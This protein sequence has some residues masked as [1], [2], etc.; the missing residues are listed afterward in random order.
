MT[1]TRSPARR[2]NAIVVALGAFT[3]AAVMVVTA[4]DSSTSTAKITASGSSHQRALAALDAVLARHEV[5]VVARASQGDPVLIARWTDNYGVDFIGDAEVRWKIEPVRTPPRDASGNPL[6]HITNP[7]PD[8]NWTPPTTGPVDASG[9]PYWQ[10]N[11]TN[12]MYRIAGEA[13]I[14]EDP[15]AG[16]GVNASGDPVIRPAVVVQG[17]RYASVLNEPLFRY[18]IFYA[19]TG[20]KGDLE[21]SHADNVNIQ[22]SVHTNG[23]LYL[24]SGLKV[25][26]KV[27]RLGALTGTLAPAATRIGPDA[28]NNLVRVNGVDGI[29]RLSKPLMYTILNG[30]TL[31]NDASPG[32]HGNPETTTGPATITWGAAASYDL[33]TASSALPL[34]LD[35]PGA[36][37]GSI[38]A[39]TSQGRSINPYRIKD[40][41]GAITEST[42]SNND[43][44]RQINNV[45]MRGVSYNN[46]ASGPLIAN[47][48][49]DT[50][51]AADAKWTDL[52][53]TST[54]PGFAG[55]ARSKL[56]GQNI[57]LLPE[58]MR[59]RSFEAQRLQ[60]I[61]TDGDPA[62][63]EHEDARPFFVKANGTSTLD[64]PQN[65]LPG[66]PTFADGNVVEDPGQYLRYALGADGRYMVRKRTGEGWRIRDLN[67]AFP[68][69]PAK[70]GLIIRERPTP[71]ADYWPGT[72]PP[73]V[74]DKIDPRWLPYAYGKHWYPNILPFTVAD[75][76]E[77]CAPSN[78]APWN[79]GGWSNDPLHATRINTTH[80]GRLPSYAAG[81]RLSITTAQNASGVTNN[82]YFGYLTNAAAGS[83]RQKPYFYAQN[84]RFVH[85][86]RQV[87]NTAQNGLR[88][89]V[90]NDAQ[91]G[92]P[93]NVS[94]QCLVGGPLAVNGDLVP[95]TTPATGIIAQPNVANSATGIQTTTSVPTSLAGARRSVRFDGFLTAAANNTYQLTA[96]AGGGSEGV[97]IWVNGELCFMNWGGVVRPNVPVRLLAGRP[98][99]IQID[100]YNNANAGYAAPSLTVNWQ[101]SDVPL[102]PLAQ[103]P[104]TA[105][106]PPLA[107]PVAN[108]G[109]A[110][111]TFTSVVVRLDKPF[112]IPGPAQ[113]KAGL[114]VR[115]GSGGMS[116]LLNGAA[117][118][119]F[120]GFSPDRGVFTERRGVRHLQEQRSYGTYFIGNGT[121]PGVP[122]GNP[123]TLVDAAGQLSYNSRVDATIT[124]T[125]TL[126]ETA[127]V[128]NLPVQNDSGIV[129]GIATD[130]TSAWSAPT[131]YA[132]PMSKAVG[133]GKIWTLLQG[134]STGPRTATRTQT[135]RK[136]WWRNTTSS[137]VQTVTLGGNV[138]AGVFND[139]DAGKNLDIFNAATGTN[140][141]W[142]NPINLDAGI[143]SGATQPTTGDRWYF[144]GGTSAARTQFKRYWATTSAS[145][146]NFGAVIGVVT[147]SRDTT[148]GDATTVW[149][150][151]GTIQINKSGEITNATAGDIATVTGLTVGT[152]NPSLTAAAPVV[153]Y[154][155]IADPPAPDF[156]EAPAVAVANFPG[157]TFQVQR[158]GATVRFDLNSF[159]TTSGNWLAAAAPQY[160][161]T[162]GS[163][164]WDLTWPASIPTT[165][166]LTQGFRPDVYTGAGG[167]G[168]SVGPVP[169][170]PTGASVAQKANGYGM[171]DDNI[172][173]ANTATS[174]WL[175]ISKAGNVLTFAYS[176]DGTNWTA[177]PQ[178]LDIA[179]WGSHLLVG[180]AVQSGDVNQLTT[181]NY[182]DMRITTTEPTPNNIIDAT[183]W[184][185][186]TSSQD[187]M[188][189][190]LASQ[191]Q[192][193][194]GSR[195]IT[196][197]FFT[198]T[199][200]ATGRRNA[201]EDWIYN[202]REFWSQ[203]RWWEHRDDAGNRVSKDDETSGT[204]T[205]FNNTPLREAY[206]KT[207]LL[208]LD[209][210]AVQSYLRQ[211]LLSAAVADL[212]IPGVSQDIQPVTSD[213]LLYTKF[214]GLIYAA[215]TNRYPWN[216]NINRWIM[217]NLL[218]VRDID[219]N[220]TGYSGDTKGVNPWSP[221]WDNQLPNSRPGMDTELTPEIGNRY[222]LSVGAGWLTVPQGHLL[223]PYTVGTV[224]DGKEITNDP[225]LKPQQFHHGVRL[226]NA[227]SIDWEFAGTRAAVNTRSIGT[228]LTKA[229]DWRWSSNPAFGLSKLSIVTP[230]SLYVQGNVNVARHETTRGTAAGA[231]AM[232]FSPLA[233]MGDS[234]VLLSNAWR[235]DKAH[236]QGLT[237][238]NVASSACV[239][240]TGT[241]ATMGTLG[242]KA[243]DTEY[244][245]ALATHNLP[246]TRDRVAEGQSSPFI[247]TMLLME[248]WNNRTMSYLGSLVVMDSRRYT[249][250]F[251]H[252]SYK[253]YG[254]TPF[255]IVDNGATWLA[256]LNGFVYQ[257]SDWAPGGPGMQRVQDNFKTGLYGEPALGVAWTGY[258]P[259]ILSE[260]TRVY[261]FNYDLL[262]EEGTPPFAP[263]GVTTSGVGGWARI[264]K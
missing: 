158:D 191:Y 80:A 122:A 53:P 144:F 239:A 227:D 157:N 164:P 219:G 49:R 153:N 206:A 82:A 261:Q 249:A 34:D 235:D 87:I 12:F 190:Y 22:G 105:Y 124:R 24:G 17:A 185:T 33:T 74:I 8:T 143:A 23:A 94:S 141:T 232:R 172:P 25:N 147:F 104:A 238:T 71:R 180:P 35:P 215:R 188:G 209:L 121:R 91:P 102:I 29:F 177:Q 203:S 14:G 30:F 50:A 72:N 254:Q 38:A 78:A 257:R 68:A 126:T 163:P 251:L 116:P 19:A 67:D 256:T 170:N 199:D 223:Q 228:S 186:T 150:T 54:A 7:P 201:S 173:I 6:N 264:I 187:I 84:W 118:Y 165:W 259:A 166:P 130:T 73:T 56:T 57:K 246:T 89:T 197:D 184:D 27:A 131:L 36:S 182:A 109:I 75:I 148:V 196:E 42:F 208:T 95:V 62:T 198:W 58:R 44:L 103:I 59:N 61:D 230:N 11:D 41:S 129:N 194:W 160:L 145:N 112:D 63:D 120:I 240:G 18:V 152:M 154:N 79:Y 212:R 138:A 241:L 39:A 171:T 9:K 69:D 237:V 16:K 176:L 99:P 128:P 70:S 155:G 161:P 66:F 195:E 98:V 55:K 229:T 83:Y 60:Y 47:D 234:V 97:R 13:R 169:V 20:A 221:H 2:G 92:A 151:S 110:T 48:S 236:A 31:Y 125:A 226:V 210:G 167:P 213:Y 117:P 175:R 101:G 77:V 142:T 140:V 174:L 100:Y 162:R 96:T 245:A 247:D 135:T 192:V 260:A 32:L 225:P 218:A 28:A 37:L 1:T 123:P 202:T 252:D 250:A 149:S 93:T 207:T 178:G 220:V 115:D 119:A 4:I 217:R 127:R 21:L 222:S 262:T 193:W 111:N 204:N 64:Y 86:G 243:S 214:N 45:A 137:S 181:A 248:N 3:F 133:G 26:D 46:A 107:S 179:N 10:S 139:T 231:T 132:G 85:L 263:I 76:A 242:S 233:L 43:S 88:V 90:F 114:M 134:F 51:R 136:G 81:G 65:A 205:T 258:S 159:V 244:N 200:P 52:S 255:G 211:R 146:Q 183:D 40:G 216:P 189:S 113:K 168:H 253:T 5:E 156:P 224:A 15:S 108:P 106:N